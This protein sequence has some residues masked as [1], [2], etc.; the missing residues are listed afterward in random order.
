MHRCQ[1]LGVC[2]LLILLCGTSF[3]RD[4]FSEGDQWLKWSDETRSAYV[5]AYLWGF[6]HGFFQ[7]CQIG[8]EIYSAKPTGLP[9]EKCIAKIP[10]DL[11]RPEQYADIITAYYQSFPS[12]RRVP[13]ARLL[14]GLQSNPNLTIQQMHE[15]YPSDTRK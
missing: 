3:A 6:E 2:A 13:I 15:Y 9:G 14:Q 4:A 11:R 8:E 5:V 1:K 12:D 7:G 10:N